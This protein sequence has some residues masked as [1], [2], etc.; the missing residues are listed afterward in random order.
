M[1]SAFVSVKGAGRTTVH[2]ANKSEGE[3]ESQRYWRR[4]CESWRD[5]LAECGRKPSRRRVHALRV[6]TLRMQAELGHLLQGF[7]HDDLAI[8]L[9]KRWHK[10]GQRLR[11]ALRPVREA[12]VH[13]GKVAWLRGSQIGSADA[14]PHCNRLCM[15]QIGRLEVQLTKLRRS[16]ARKLTTVINERRHQWAQL[17]GEIEEAVLPH[18]SAPAGATQKALADSI[19]SLGA[20][21]PYL[22]AENLHEF[23]KRI[24]GIRYLVDLSASSD[25]L[26]A[27]QAAALGKMQV[28]IGEWHDWQALANKAEE[29][30]RDTAA[31]ELVDLL[32]DKE[33]ESLHRALGVCRRFSGRLLHHESSTARTAPQKSI[34]KKFSVRGVE[35]VISLNQK[36][37]A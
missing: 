23:R 29:I 14:M 8:R 6:A 25:P 3:S 9:V 34:P 24:K 30:L 11:R 10:H 16:A 21:V 13:L 4:E 26:A 35:P 19:N 2:T 31:D 20:E 1:I 27:R 12:D 32:R 37:C 7:E 5:L 15:K 36:D 33:A 17:N 22:K 28:A 18:A